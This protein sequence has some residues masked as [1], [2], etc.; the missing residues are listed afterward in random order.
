[1][2]VNGLNQYGQPALEPEVFAALEKIWGRGRVAAVHA[3]QRGP[4]G[5]EHRVCI[6]VRDAERESVFKVWLLPSQVSNG[7]SEAV[8]A[9]RSAVKGRTDA[10]DK[11]R[12]E[13]AGR[14]VSKRGRGRPRMTDA[15]AA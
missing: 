11:N 4:Q 9:V 6:D 14:G 7:T 8:Q 2:G 10:W 3:T 15:G 5:R 1:M 13:N 12:P